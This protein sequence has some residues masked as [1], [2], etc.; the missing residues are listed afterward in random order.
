MRDE[1]YPDALDNGD[2]EDIIKDRLVDIVGDLLMADKSFARNWSKDNP[3]GREIV[4]T[5]NDVIEYVRE[6]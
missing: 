6:N 1:G 5:D 2:W 4:S 3:T